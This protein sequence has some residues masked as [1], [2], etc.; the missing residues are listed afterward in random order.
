VT[1]RALSAVP[2]YADEI[3]PQTLADMEG[4]FTFKAVRGRAFQIQVDGGEVVS[5]TVR[6]KPDAALD[7]LVVAVPRRAFVQVDLGGRTDL[8]DVA[9]L[10]NA[11]GE[12]VFLNIT[13]TTV[14]D[15]NSM[16]IAWM[17]SDMPIQ[18]GRTEVGSTTEGDYTCVLLQ[19]GQEV[20]RIPAR[21]GGKGVTILR[22]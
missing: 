17:S 9:R 1:V 3:G 5:T 4:R 13:R 8:A 19:K 10:V 14:G 11:A 15:M 21:L 12:P 22:P 20:A 7:D 16:S 6:V 2:G 18:D